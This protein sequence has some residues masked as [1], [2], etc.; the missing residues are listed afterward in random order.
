[1]NNIPAQT[2]NDWLEQRR[3]CIPPPLV[4]TT[5]PS[6]DPDYYRKHKPPKP[7]AYLNPDLINMDNIC[8]SLVATP[9]LTIIHALAEKN[10][11]TVSDKYL[12]YKYS[13][14]R[15]CTICNSSPGPFP[16]LNSSTI[17]HKHVS[18]LEFYKK[19]VL[20]ED[21]LF[22]CP[23]CKLSPHLAFW[24]NRHELIISSS[25]IKNW[26]SF[27]VDKPWN[28]DDLHS[29]SIT[30]P[31]ARIRHVCHA[32][33]TELQ[34]FKTPFTIYCVVGLNDIDASTDLDMTP[35]LEDVDKLVSVVK[36]LNPDHIVRFITV[37]MPPRLSCLGQDDYGDRMASSNLVDKTKMI[38]QLNTKYQDIN[39]QDPY[40]GSHNGQNPRLVGLHLRGLKTRRSDVSYGHYISD[41]GDFAHFI[42]TAYHCKR[43][44]RIHNND[45]DNPD[46]FMNTMHLSN[47]MIFRSGLSI[48][49]AICLTNDVNPDNWASKSLFFN[50]TKNTAATTPRRYYDMRDYGF[51]MATTFADLSN[52]SKNEDLANSPHFQDN[53]SIADS[54]DSSDCRSDWEIEVDNFM[55]ELDQTAKI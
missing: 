5:L 21:G 22:A 13:D 30:I 11:I 52:T 26:R 44:W 34:S 55:A 54:S 27:S 41:F 14:N 49:R 32:L 10:I 24:P 53:E 1:M 35:I 47:S 9:D 15:G 23:T 25:T 40:Y 37:P 28:G 45:V 48:Y 51:P 7:L 2:L 20:T 6:P 8:N 16:E 46:W 39:S 19:S 42:A 12:R 4:P 17:V 36:A 3:R 43:E 31:G 29:W 50:Q 38:V 18:T 33:V